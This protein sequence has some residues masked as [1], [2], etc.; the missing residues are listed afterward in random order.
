MKG[1]VCIQTKSGLLKT[2]GIEQVTNTRHLY[3]PYMYMCMGMTICNLL[4]A[5][6]WMLLSNQIFELEYHKME[7]VEVIMGMPVGC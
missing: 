5:I 1:I 7:W 3:K 2:M 4:D 6:C